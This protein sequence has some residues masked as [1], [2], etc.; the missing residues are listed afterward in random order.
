MCLVLVQMNHHLF[1]TNLYLKRD[2]G[3][4]SAV[5]FPAVFPK[6]SSIYFPS[7]SSR[8]TENVEEHLLISDIPSLS[9]MGGH[10]KRSPITRCA[11]CRKRCSASCGAC[12]QAFYCSKDH[13]RTHWQQSHKLECQGSQMVTRSRDCHFQTAHVYGQ[14]SS[15]NKDTVISAKKGK[16]MS[17]PNSSS[18]SETTVLHP[19]PPPQSEEGWIVDFEVPQPSKSPSEFMN[20]VGWILIG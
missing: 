9:V 11:V 5:Y 14:T 13:Q 16:I 7:M 3:V 17:E 19:Q 20:E 18:S 1:H 15:Q 12:H 10:A 2:S 8:K 4:R 6:L